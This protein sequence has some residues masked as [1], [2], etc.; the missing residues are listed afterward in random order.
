MVCPGIETL[1]DQSI[2]GIMS[3]PGICDQYFWAKIMAALFFILSLILFQN[4]RAR[5][6]KADMI[7]SMG[8]S[9]IAIIFISLI[10][11][12]VGFIQTDI[13]IQIFVAGMV[14]IVIW[15]LKK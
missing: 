14:F 5:E 15:M 13:F 1:T 4:D 8:V 9:A 3:Y 2:T 12:L 6:T 7:S 11:T 10:G